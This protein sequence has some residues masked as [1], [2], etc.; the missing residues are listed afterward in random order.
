MRLASFK[1][2][3]SNGAEADV[4]VVSL[5][6]MAGGDLAN[7]N[8]W[9]DQLKLA[10]VSENELVSISSH[11]SAN[12]HDFLVTDLVSAKPLPPSNRK[13][14]ILAAASQ[15]GEQTWFVKMTGDVDLVEAQKN[16]FLDFLRGLSISGAAGSDESSANE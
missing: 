2:T 3:G 8:R 7:I 11:V 14:R 13:I 1:V 12:G 4:S 15:Q 16:H 6:G 10:P 9:R 5:A